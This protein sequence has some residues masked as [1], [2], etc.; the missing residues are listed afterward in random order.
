[1]RAYK[2]IKRDFLEWLGKRADTT[3]EDITS[4]EITRFRHHL[5]RQGLSEDTITKLIRKFLNSSFHAA[6]R[7][8]KIPV[9]PCSFVETKTKTKC[10]RIRKGTFTPKQVKA[11][12]AEARR[13]ERACH[14]R[15]LHRWP[16]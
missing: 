13:L 8:G 7:L 4:E 3:I 10:E 5:R 12:V 6:W 14:C 11:I 9:N 1:M 2:Q 16:C 15:I